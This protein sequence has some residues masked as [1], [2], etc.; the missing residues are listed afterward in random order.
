MRIVTVLALT[1][2]LLVPLGAQAQYVKEDLLPKAAEAADI[3]AIHMPDSKAAG[4]AFKDAGFRYEGVFS[5]FH[6]YSMQGRRLLAGITLTSNRRQGCL[7]T[8][9]KMTVQDGMALI[10]PWLK[11]SSAKPTKP[12]D[13]NHAAAWRGT[14]RKGP[15]NLVVLKH[16]DFRIMRG[17]AIGAISD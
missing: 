4:T 13:S 3:C 9:S 10:Q 12:V 17:A 16:V 11:E 8:V 6:L 14:F 1:L 5:D 2:G 7:I 15:I